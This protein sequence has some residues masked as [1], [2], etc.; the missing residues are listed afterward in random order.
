MY[1]AIV[2][3]CRF[4]HQTALFSVQCQVKYDNVQA[5]HELDSISADDSVAD[6]LPIRQHHTPQWQWHCH[7]SYQHSKPTE[8]MMYWRNIVIIIINCELCNYF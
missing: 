4:W 7:T 6:G 3:Y 8:G 2:L 5:V 1:N